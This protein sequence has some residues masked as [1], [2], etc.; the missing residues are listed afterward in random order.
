MRD[1]VL[2]DADIQQVMDT[3]GRWLAVADGVPEMV[4]HGDT[5]DEAT[6]DLVA[7]LNTITFH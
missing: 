1:V 3:P 7:Q 5:E 4:G 2:W 6:E